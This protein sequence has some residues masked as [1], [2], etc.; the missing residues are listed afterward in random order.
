MEF[1]RYAEQA[2]LPDPEEVLADPTLL[3]LDRR[4][5]LVLATLA[6]VTA[7]VAA[8]CTEERWNA[9]WAV[10]AHVCDQGVADM[11]ALAANHLLPL[12]DP[13]WPA[14]ATATAFLP[15]LREAALV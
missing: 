12:R 10:L 2:D 3:R 5:D 14:P 13:S 6:A 15:I 1:M 9:G 4:S 8:E 11:A 7:A